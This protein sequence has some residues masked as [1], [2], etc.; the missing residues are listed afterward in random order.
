MNINMIFDMIP[1]ETYLKIVYFLHF[2]KKLNLKNPVTYNEKL[3]WLK[4]HDRKEQYTLLADK[5]SVKEYVKNIL[6]E[7]YIIQTLGVWNAPEMIEYDKLPNSFIL[8]CTHDSGS[9][10]ICTDKKRIDRCKVEKKFRKHL[11]VNYYYY[12]LREWQYK[13]IS[14]RI[15]AEK[16][17]E[18]DGKVPIDYKFFCFNGK[19]KIVM[20]VHDRN[21]S[22]R[23]GFYNMK[24][25]RLPLR[26]ENS[27][28]QEMDKKPINFE[29]MI[30]VAEKLSQDL[31]HVRVDLYNMDGKIYFG[32]MTFHHWGGFGHIIPCEWEGILGNWIEL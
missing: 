27:G 24:F 10:Y 12:Y 8:K 5:L 31:R 14:P 26:I 1:D 15:F 9:V 23:T 19:A 2:G 29:E 20:I 4:I 32:E 11:K 6:G 30:E 16:Y 13:N 3:Q 7:E 25:E 28:Y 22:A 18:K 17:I 21:Q